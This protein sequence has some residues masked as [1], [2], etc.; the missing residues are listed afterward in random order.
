M[1]DLLFDT[2]AYSLFK[3]GNE[4]VL[5]VV[6]EADRIFMNAIVIGEL[7]AGFDGGRY[8]EANRQELKEFLQARSVHMVP[9]TG[10]TAERYSF[11]FHEL[12]RQGTPVPTHDLWIAASAMESGASILTADRHF[13]KIRQVPVILIST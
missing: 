12:K 13:N 3:R 1:K 6:R 8:R 2:S 9:L 10:Q 5:N 11:I 7:L 4:K